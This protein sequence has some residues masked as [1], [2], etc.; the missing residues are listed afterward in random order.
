MYG[1]RYVFICGAN[2]ADL[3]TPD[4]V[5][6]SNDSGFLLPFFVSLELRITTT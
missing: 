3:E 1:I 5:L 4:G 6:Q 2:N